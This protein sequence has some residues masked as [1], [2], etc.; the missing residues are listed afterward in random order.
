MTPTDYR[1]L[2]QTALLAIALLLPTVARAHDAA[3]HANHAT[4]VQ[5]AI[6]IKVIDAPLRSHDN[7]TVRLA[8]D[9]LAGKIAII[10]FV[11]TSC[12]SFCPVASALMNSVRQQLGARVGKDVVLVTIS[13][14]PQRDT[15]ARLAAYASQFH[16]GPGWTWL[17]GT[18]RDIDAVLKG[19][20]AYTPNFEDHPNMLLVGNA[21]TGE[22][23]RFNGLP[24][25]KLVAERVARAGSPDA[26]TKG[27]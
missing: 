21:A 20:G 25:A 7:K 27:Q 23:T 8:S 6:R 10:D 13:V 19:L 11:Y 14:D 18:R 3:A 1:R 22:W 12:T 24:D 26:P 9:V 2:A 17:T 4:T 15:P 5:S 16:T